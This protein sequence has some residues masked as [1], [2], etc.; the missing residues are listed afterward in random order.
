MKLKIKYL[1]FIVLPITITILLF[2]A[3]STSNTSADPDSTGNASIIKFSHSLHKDIAEC[4]VCHASVK[5][6][7]SIKD[8]LL[9][10]H[11]VCKQCH[12]EVD[13]EDQCSKCHYG[14]KYE[15]LIQHKAKNIIFDHSFHLDKQK[16]K[17]EACHKG[18]SEVDYGY[19]ATQPYPIMENCYSCHSDKGKAT[20]SCEACHISTANL[21]PLNHQSVNFIKSHKFTAREMNANCIMCHDNN[22]SCISCHAANNIISNMNTPTDFIAP[23]LPNNFVDGTKQQQITRVHDLNY[24]YTHGI[25]LKGKTEECQSCHETETFCGNCH[26]SKNSDFSMG[27][28]VPTSHFA[29]DFVTGRGVGTGGGKHS[30]LARRDIESC[31]SCHDV[32]GADPTCITCHTDADGIKGTD[33][34]THPSGFMH[35]IHGDWHD[36]NAS[37]CFNCHTRFPATP[38]VKFCGY[39]HGAK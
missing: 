25:D 21:K 5:T 11:E 26:S 8:R 10:N 38:G 29:I 36:S 35:N 32:Q 18:I 1:Y 22:N 17:C 6:S 28:I 14:E 9:P 23:Y 37:V 39:C 19:K 4:D 27:G 2:S 31:Q 24:V 3:F 7:K 12:E 16:L 13:K 30:I 34:K 20:S 33:P 15:P